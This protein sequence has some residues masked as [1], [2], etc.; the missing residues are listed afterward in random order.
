MAINGKVYDVTKFL[1]DHPG[2]DEVMKDT[3]GRD[4]TLEFDDVGHSEEALA[5]MVPMYIG[6]FE[7]GNVE[8][9]KD[10]VVQ[11]PKDKF[12]VRQPAS[13]GTGMGRLMVPIVIILITLAVRYFLL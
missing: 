13:A 9:V 5:L 10:Q 3:A 4:A 1:D 7:G 8:N 12:P 11:V 6:V 2:G